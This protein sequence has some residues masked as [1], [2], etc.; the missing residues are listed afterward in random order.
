[1]AGQLLSKTPYGIV[2]PW[3]VEP[4]TGSPSF[5]A[6]PQSCCPIVEKQGYAMGS[7]DIDKPLN[8]LGGGCFLP[9]QLKALG[10]QAPGWSGAALR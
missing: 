5:R 8:F 9:Q 7:M 6:N 1:M 3:H 4:L 2:G 10:S